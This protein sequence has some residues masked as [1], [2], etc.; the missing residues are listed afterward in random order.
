MMPGLGGSGWRV[1]VS[2]GGRGW[3]MGVYN[4]AGWLN[5]NMGAN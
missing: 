2:R 4:R 5:L 1:D 3:G